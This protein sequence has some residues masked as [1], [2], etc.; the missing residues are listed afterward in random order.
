MSAYVVEPV[1]SVP[2]TRSMPGPSV[3]IAPASVSAVIVTS[4]GATGGASVTVGA[5]TGAVTATGCETVAVVIVA[6][7]ALI[8]AGADS[9]VAA[10]ALCWA[11]AS[12]AGVLP[13]PA[14]GAAGASE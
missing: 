11:G 4:S 3:T 9:W 5:A 14:A 1:L 8:V 13:V 10:G 2:V 7:P 12:E 6:L